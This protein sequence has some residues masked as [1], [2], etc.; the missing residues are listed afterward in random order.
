[1][2]VPACYSPGAAGLLSSNS[3]HEASVRDKHIDA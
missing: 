1:M 3:A 2:S